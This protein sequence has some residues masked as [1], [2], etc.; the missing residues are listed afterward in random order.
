[1][2]VWLQVKPQKVAMHLHT[3]TGTML[4]EPMNASE[5]TE[6]GNASYTGTIIMLYQHMNASEDTESGSNP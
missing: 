6:T 3:C 4:H 1:M 5:G 2:N